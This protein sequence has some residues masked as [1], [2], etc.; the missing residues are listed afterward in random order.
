MHKS[1]IVNE[2]IFRK[3]EKELD[4]K[5]IGCEW[6]CMRSSLIILTS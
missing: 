1:G 5:E 4:L 2:E 6:R 3:S